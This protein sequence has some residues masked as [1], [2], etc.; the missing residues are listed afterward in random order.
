M[1]DS[2][3]IAFYAAALV[4]IGAFCNWLAWRLNLPAILFLLLVGLVLGPGLGVLD[5]DAALGDLLFPLVSLGVAIILFEGALTL[6][7]SDIRHVRRII[8]NLTTVGVLVTW[9]VMGAAA[10]YLVG[11]DWPLAL[12]FGALVTVTGPTVVAPLL[13]SIR[14]SSRVANILHWEGILIDPIGAALVVLVFEFIHSGGGEAASLLEFLKVVLIGTV[15]G[16]A[17][18]FALAQ[19]LKRHW[20]PDFLENY[21]SLAVVLVVFTGANVLGKESG[22]IAVTVLGI[23]LANTRGLDVRELVSFK[24]DLTLLLLTVLFIL[25]AARLQVD[26][27]LQVLWPAFGL[28]AVALFVAR[29]LSVWLSGLGTSVT[30]REKILLSW[31]APRGIVAAA[32]SSLFALRLAADGNEQAELLVPLTFVI[33]IGTVVVQSLTAGHLAKALGLSSRDQD[34]VLITSANRVALALGEALHKVGVTVMVV[35]TDRSGLHS[36][37]MRGLPTFYGNPISEYTERYLEMTPYNQLLA[38]SRSHDSNMV[39]CSQFRHQ[40]DKRSI[41]TIRT[42]GVDD[43]TDEAD[44]V[45]EL[46][47]TPLFQEGTTWSK[48]ASLLSQGAEIRSTQLTEEYG[49][50]DYRE[51]MGSGALPLFVLD[52]EGRLQWIT[53]QDR[54]DPGPGWT[55]ASLLPAEQVETLNRERHRPDEGQ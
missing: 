19:V 22:L 31:V 38:V 44:V 13:R 43:V 2:S 10:H 39:V 41:Y 48:L 40:F 53:G 37:R 55:L 12:L 5:P 20:L 45:P 11:L 8:R 35:D 34:G 9:G 36:A 17:A 29:P 6:R 25:L 33:I 47:F 18:G 26:D 50:D 15:I 28:L 16:L 42:G 24:E 32:V 4:G 49:L 14:P 30:T 51:R 23:V 3:L 52:N 54:P 46:R 27:L 7:F 1:Q 21:T